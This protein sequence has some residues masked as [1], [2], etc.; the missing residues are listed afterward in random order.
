MSTMAATALLTLSVLALRPSRLDLGSWLGAAALFLA[1]GLLTLGM[2]TGRLRGRIG[3]ALTAVG[4]AAIAWA[5]GSWA[6]ATMSGSH[7]EGHAVVL[8]TA[9]AIQ[10]ALTMWAAAGPDA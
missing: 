2:V 1:Q 8:G 3:R 7:F 9:L 10:G 6:W 4:G 5:G